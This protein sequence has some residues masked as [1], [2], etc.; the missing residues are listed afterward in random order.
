MVFDIV[1]VP[2]ITPIMARAEKA[3]CRVC[4]GFNMLKYQGYKQFELFTG[5]NYEE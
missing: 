3:G 5:E 4:N 2:E 1:Y